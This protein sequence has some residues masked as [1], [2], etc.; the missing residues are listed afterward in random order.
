MSIWLYSDDVHDTRTVVSAI[1]LTECPFCRSPLDLLKHDRESVPNFATN[2]TVKACSKCGWWCIKK[3]SLAL[4]SSARP[5]AARQRVTRPH[6]F[7]LYGAVAS[8]KNLDVGNITTPLQEVRDY[9]TAKYESRFQVHPQL[10]EQVVASVFKDVGYHTRV[11]AYSGDDGIDVILDGPTGEEVGVQVKRYSNRIEVEQIRSLA[12]ALVLNGLTK[13]VFVTT[14]TF[15]SGASS[16]VT[17][18]ARRGI[19]IE[20]VDAP[21]FLQ[22]LKIAQRQRYEFVQEPSTPFQSA[23]LV[24]LT[25]DSHPGFKVRSKK[26]RFKRKRR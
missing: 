1:G 19:D 16:T 20:L 4:H 9:L 13:G 18:F 22:A 23:A 14:S 10:F 15:Q 17:R 6:Q 8:L 21:R 7:Q 12:G 3:T 25:S 11:T 24:H 2:L 5:S 26:S